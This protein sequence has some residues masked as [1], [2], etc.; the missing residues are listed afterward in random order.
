MMTYAYIPHRRESFMKRFAL[1]IA[2][3]VSI[4]VPAGSQQRQQP[5]VTGPPI[6]ALPEPRGL[7]GS[8]ATKNQAL[9]ARIVALEKL[10][11]EAVKNKDYTALGSLM[12]EEYCEIDMDGR[13]AKTVALDNARNI[14]LTNYSMSDVKL[15]VLG[16]DAALLTYK[17]VFTGT[18]KGEAMPTQPFYYGVVYMRRNGKWLAAFAQETL[19][20]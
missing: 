3:A 18:F 10:S 5:A 20:K 11:W 14:A 16:K 4:A 9:E 13:R 2:V 6:Q 15:S 7:P 12:A 19:S 17:V 1:S 8:A